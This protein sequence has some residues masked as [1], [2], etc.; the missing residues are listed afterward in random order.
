MMTQNLCLNKAKDQS[1]RA[2]RL[3]IGKYIAELATRK[4]LTVNQVS[5]ALCT[6]VSLFS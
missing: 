3:P 6:L 1:I 2:A 4:V 5:A